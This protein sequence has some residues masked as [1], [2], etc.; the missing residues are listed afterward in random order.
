M[1]RARVLL[2]D[3]DAHQLEHTRAVVSQLPLVDV[4]AEL[5]SSNAVKRIGTEAFDLV[6]TDI[7]MPLIDGIDLLRVALAQDPGLPVVVMT[8]FPTVD[9]AVEA[10]KAGAADYLT[11]PINPDELSVVVHRVL[12]GRRVRAERD[13][14]ERRLG[15]E[16]RFGDM[17][18]TSAPMRAV[19]ELVRQFAAT[20]IDVLVV[21]E[22]GTGKELVARGIHQGGA[23]TG[24]F[25][26]IDC[27]AMP[28][29]LLES[30]LFGHEKGA[31]T[32]AE[33]RTLGLMEFADRGTFFLDEVNTLP[34]R[35]QSKLLRALQERSFRRVGGTTET[36]VDLRVVAAS[37][38]DLA[39]LVS[40]G[41][42]REDL[43]YRL[44][45]GLIE[46][47][48]LR[49]RAD[50]IPLLV[51]HFLERQRHGDRE[52]PTLSDDA[53]EVFLGYSWPGNVRQLENTL[54]RMT[55]V[56]RDPVLTVSDIPSEISGHPSANGG[57]GTSPGSFF[58]SRAKMQD[59]FERAY[60]TSVLRK[61][62][63]DVSLAATTA[64]VPRGTFY[65]LLKK[66][67]LNA[68]LFRR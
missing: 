23:R 51:E 36:E 68:D 61:A 7:R 28:E 29:H 13:L 14:L 20:D 17:I 26:P 55:A 60:L 67:G 10:L 16:H 48:P 39:T 45:V 49:D 41:D 53:M 58:E 21:G 18:G 22:T 59:R 54:R 63:G 1:P 31:F 56:C 64:Q 6:L 19:F 66:H 12:D 35:L 57:V 2:V 4:V 24:R 42:F 43:Y 5:R 47:P 34:L 3:D 40:E 37:N 46:I 52:P 8:A 32:G 9:T 38:Q 27:G 50:D 15:N 33:R 62:G 44:H 25:V 65:R 30:E 11:K